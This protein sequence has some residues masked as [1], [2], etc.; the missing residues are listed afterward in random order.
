[1]L[2][3]RNH[4]SMILPSR[5]R[6]YFNI[7]KRLFA[8]ESALHMQA[9]TFENLNLIYAVMLQVYAKCLLN[10]PADNC[11]AAVFDIHC[12]K[13]SDI[14]SEVDPSYDPMLLKRLLIIQ[15]RSLRRRYFGSP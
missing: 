9:Q 6:P 14:Q 1:M 3:E 10:R 4:Y 2:N 11:H 15:P 13:H 7:K 12:H 8:L 5:L